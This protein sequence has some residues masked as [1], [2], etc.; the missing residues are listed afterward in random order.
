[1]CHRY[2]TTHVTQTSL[3]YFERLRQLNL[4]TLKYRRLQGDKIKVFKITH[5]YYDTGALVKLNFNPVGSTRGNK[6]KLRK[7]MCR[8]DIRKYSFC[9]QV[10]NVWTSLPDYVVEADSAN[11][12]KSRFDKYWANQEFVFNL[13]S[14]LIGTGG[15]PVRM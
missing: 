6:F 1:M 13:N 8:Y 9:Y 3:P 7:D 15:L 14:E 2:S 5:N 11:S 12:F 4:P 10:V